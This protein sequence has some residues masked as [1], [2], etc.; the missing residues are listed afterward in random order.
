MKLGDEQVRHVAKLARLALSADEIAKYG[1][2]LSAILD[3][4]DA[5]S[6]VD[7]S[8]VEPTSMG[9]SGPP[10]QREDRVSGEVGTSVALK[11][12][13]AVQGAHFSIPKVIE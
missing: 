9:A 7:T 3:A 6:Q 4:V 8:N 1:Q 5:L 10:H 2:Q 13:P 11:N 12:A